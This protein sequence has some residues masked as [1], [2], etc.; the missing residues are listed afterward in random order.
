MARYK[1][2]QTKQLLWDQDFSVRGHLI[3]FALCFF[4]HLCPKFLKKV[5]PHQDSYVC[6]EEVLCICGSS[7]MATGFLRLPTQP[8]SP[9]LRRNNKTISCVHLGMILQNPTLVLISVQL[10]VL[11]PWICPCF[12]YVGTWVAVLASQSN[13]CPCGSRRSATFVSHVHH[14]M[15]GWC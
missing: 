6:Y 1:T 13:V 2:K 10:R 7:L 8:F 12:I 9:D 15:K 4:L 14:T 3:S 5:F 11:F